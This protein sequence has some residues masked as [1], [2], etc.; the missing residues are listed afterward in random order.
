M[1]EHEPHINELY[2]PG[3]KYVSFAAVPRRQP[4]HPSHASPGQ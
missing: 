2:W 1:A 3:T 4:K